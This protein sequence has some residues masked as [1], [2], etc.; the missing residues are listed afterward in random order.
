MQ[1]QKHR[2]VTIHYTLANNQGEVIDSS[3]GQD[4][5][6]YIHG[7]NQLVSGLEKALEGK[8]TGEQVSVTVAPE[9]GYGPVLPELFQEVPRAA[10][11][12]IE[13]LEPGLHLQAQTEE[14]HVRHVRVVKVGDD[15]VE[16]DINHPLAG[17]ELYFD[18]SIEQ[19]RDASEEEVEHGHVH[20]GDGHSH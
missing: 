1:I 10:F 6:V 9:E 7:V 5:L 8:A 17:E 18:V 14:G 13:N 20:G 15:T 12:N 11:D 19:V 3:E 2:V 16:I 4:P